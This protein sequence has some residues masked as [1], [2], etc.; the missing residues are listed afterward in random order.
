[1]RMSR[2]IATP[3]AVALIGLAPVAAASSASAA[4]TERA[5]VAASSVPSSAASSAA[6][7]PSREIS[8]KIVEPGDKDK[9][10]IKG[11][12]GPKYEERG[13][14]VQRKLKGQ[15]KW[16]KFKTAKTDD[17]SRYRTRVQPKKSD[18]VVYYRVKTTK[19]DQWKASYSGKVGIKTTTY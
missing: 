5:V 15:A 18:G 13:Y 7:K 17:E 16:S 10:F 1:M 8:I 4:D 19:T 6:P 12:I 11:K 2:I 14:T 3:V 9:F